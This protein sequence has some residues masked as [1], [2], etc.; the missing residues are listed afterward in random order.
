LR[1]GLAE[2]D[3]LTGSVLAERYLASVR[4][5]W[6]GQVPCQ[7]T[8]IEE[9]V[10]ASFAGVVLSADLLGRP[11]WLW[12]EAWL[13]PVVDQG[14][15]EQL[16]QPPLVADGH[17][18]VA[19]P[20]VRVIA[21]LDLESGQP[22]WRYAD[23]DLVA[24]V[25]LL[26]ER[27]VVRTASG[28]VG[29]DTA[30]GEPVWSHEGGDLLA[31]FAMDGRAGLLYARRE[32]L[33]DGSSRPRFVWLDPQ[34]GTVTASSP[35]EGFVD[36]SPMLGPIVGGGEQFLAFAGRSDQSGVREIV[37]LRPVGPADPAA[38]ASLV[39]GPPAVPRP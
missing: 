34:T 3:P 35:L 30:T 10:V 23:A 29:L 32:R 12:R 1:I 17:V 28:F 26:G 5:A 14:W 8:A 36:P 25:G 2:F 9:H 37:V 18:F 24:I 19:Q 6:N 33:S 39:P 15:M 38:D 16:H 22:H 13:P 4:D 20:G 21:C 27:L 7:A 31:A 11:R